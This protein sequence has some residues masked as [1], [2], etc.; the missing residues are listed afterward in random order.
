MDD[1]SSAAPGATN[2]LRRADADGVATLTLAHPA[3]R[4]AL[5]IAMLDALSR[6]LAD[7]AADRAIRCVVLAADGPA[8]C[9]GHD[10]K[11]LTT[12][13]AAP[14]GGEAFFA[15]TMA[16]CSAFM[17]A[18]RDLPQPVIAA[19]EGVA[20]AAGCQLVAACDLAVAGNTARFCTPGVDIGLFCST[21]AVALARNV[22]RKR[23]MEMLLTGEMIDASEA[24]RIGLVNRVALPGRAGA[25]ARELAREIAAKPSHTIAL[26][27][28]TFHAQIERGLAEAYD[29]ASRAMVVNLLD[30]EAREGIA[31]F[32]GK[33]KP[34][35]PR[36]ES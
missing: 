33:R 21:P 32:L 25:A 16:R 35:W 9:S 3:S 12:A 17:R 34:V 23:A 26:G 27:K 8:F 11:E 13:R 20:T 1:Q 7:I 15:D 6:S 36:H 2:P 28:R 22:S 19:V 30:D 4:N 29:I 24:L 14:D 31:A 5:S 18:I 10:L